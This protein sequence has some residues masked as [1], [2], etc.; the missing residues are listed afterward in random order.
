MN[1]VNTDVLPSVI[2]EEWSTIDGEHVYWSNSNNNDWLGYNYDILN[3]H[4][5][6][7]ATLGNYWNIPSKDQVQEL[8]DNTNM[9]EVTINGIT[10]CQYTS[11]TDST[12]SIFL[13]N[14]SMIFKSYDGDSFLGSDRNFYM[15]KNMDRED[16]NNC[17]E[18]CRTYY[19]TENIISS[20]CIMTSYYRSEY[21]QIRPVYNRFYV[22]QPKIIMLKNGDGFQVRRS[23]KIE[24]PWIIIFVL[25]GDIYTP[26][27]INNRLEVQSQY[28]I[29]HLINYFNDSGF[30]EI[31]GAILNDSNLQPTSK[32][33][34]G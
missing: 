23:N 15:I 13:P 8:F 4:D 33:Q 28:G 16:P 32:N 3:E 2:E 18:S 17:G 20:G 25:E 9:T 1:P 27:D 5:A 14:P 19:F 11:K 7:R 21:Q 31:R 6:A 10:G 22:K 29:Q 30:D 24:G 26:V 12:K 34:F